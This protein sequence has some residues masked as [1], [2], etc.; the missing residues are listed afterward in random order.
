M[1][2]NLDASLCQAENASMNK[3]DWIKK[4]VFSAELLITVLLTFTVL[5]T[6]T[7]ACDGGCYNSSGAAYYYENAAFYSEFDC[8][9]ACEFQGWGDTAAEA[10]GCYGMSGGIP[11]C[12][13]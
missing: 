9:T 4:L 3:K 12:G 10:C 5:T 13:C 6:P 11:W 8:P 1:L 7:W 2:I